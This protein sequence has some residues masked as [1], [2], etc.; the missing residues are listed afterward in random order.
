MPCYHPMPAYRMKDGT[1]KFVE[2][3]SVEGHL[4]LPCGQCIGCRLER[5]RQWAIRCIHEA[6]LH[7][8]NCFVTLTYDDN[9]LPAN[10]SL[11]YRDVQL[12]LKRL[13]KL[14]APQRVRFFCAGEYGDELTRPHY[15]LCLFGYT[16]TDRYSVKK[17]LYGSPTLDKLWPYGY[18]SF[19]A[20]TFES[21]AYVARYCL[22][23]V[24]GRDARQHYEAGVDP[25]TGE[26]LQ[27]QPEFTHMSLKPGIGAGWFNKYSTEVYPC[28]EVIINGKPVK[29]PKYYDKLYDKI[30]F[31]DLDQIRA[32]RELDAYILRGDNTS[33]RLA[34]KEQVTTARSNLS[35]RNL[36]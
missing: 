34:V 32:Q 24:N 12:F 10:G 15:H 6:S 19:G 26:V 22:K 16:P 2:R 33:E 35:S 31:N 9:H 1:V 3:G 8:Q 25:D 4:T 36:S 29:P 5:S 28:D 21:A 27:L 13:R 11:S 23:K 30:P 7:K 20:V 14:I 17:D 18:V